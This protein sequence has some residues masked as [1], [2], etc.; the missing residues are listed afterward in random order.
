M[1]PLIS[2]IYTNKENISNLVFSYSN[3]NDINLPDNLRVE[4]PLYYEIIIRFSEEDRDYVVFMLDNDLKIIDTFYSKLN[5][6]VGKSNIISENY[7]PYFEKTDYKCIYPISSSNEKIDTVF[8]LHLDRKNYLTLF[9]EKYSRT[10]Y[11]NISEKIYGK[12]ILPIL[13]LFFNNIN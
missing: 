3:T 5:K 13:K 12:I 6:W 8:C 10:F 11:K 1:Y 7:L 4:Y 2:P 9:N